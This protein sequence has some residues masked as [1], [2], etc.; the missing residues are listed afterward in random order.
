MRI[1]LQEAIKTSEDLLG[2]LRELDGLELGD[3]PGRAMRRRRGQVTRRL[4]RLAHDCDRARV[5]VMD[6]YFAYKT[7]DD[8]EGEIDPADGDSDFG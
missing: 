1:D 6:A 8:P 4:L 3:T 2:K 5:Q 7:A